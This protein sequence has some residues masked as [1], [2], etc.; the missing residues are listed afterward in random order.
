MDNVKI[1]NLFIKSLRHIKNIEDNINKK[2]I[3][4]IEFNNDL[5]KLLRKIYV[6]TLNYFLET[7][8]CNLS[9]NVLVSEYILSKEEKEIDAINVISTK[10]ANTD[11]YNNCILYIDNN[12]IRVKN[13]T[14]M[15]I[16]K[17]NP[18]APNNPPMP[19]TN[20]Y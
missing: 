13:I 4:N 2:F 12:D 9:F 3:N 7:G 16:T 17:N 6:K 1:C 19:Q 18:T 20:P 10:N 14:N 15:F 8:L 11:I 5:L